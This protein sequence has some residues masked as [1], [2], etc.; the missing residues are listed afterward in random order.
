[1]LDYSLCNLPPYKHQQVGI[2]KIFNEI[3][4][5]LFDEMGAGKT[6]QVIAAAQFLY[7]AGIINRVIV[8]APAAVRSVWYHPEYG[9]IKK[10]SFKGLKK[11]VHSFHAKTD[12]WGDTQEPFLHWM[13]T[14]YEFVRSRSRLDELLP[15]CTSK[16]LLVLDES[17]AIKNYK[18]EQTKA[19]FEIRAKCGR[20]VILNG[21]PIS[22]NPGDLYTQSRIMHFDILGCKTW[23]NYRARYGVLGGFMNRQIIEWRNLEDIQK[24]LAPHVLRRLKIDC[25][26]LPPKL[27]PVTIAVPLTPATWEVYRN[28]RDEMVSWLSDGTVSTASQAIVKAMRL[29]QI[30]SGFLGGM[31]Q[32]S[33]DMDDEEHEG[34]G[35]PIPPKFLSAEKTGAF[36][37]WYKDQLELDPN[38][39]VLIWCRFRA[40]VEGVA[41]QFKLLFPKTQIGLIWG[42][43]KPAERDAAK[44]LLDPRSMPE[45]PVAVIGTPATGSMGLTMTGT[46]VVVYLSNDFSLKTR[47]QSEDRVHRPGQTQPVSYFDYVATGPKGQK[48]IDH[49][50][51]KALR[52]KEDIANWTTSA[53]VNA[54]LEE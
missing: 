15:F 18:A 3:Y 33:F 5:G 27:E 32:I 23:F 36:M 30:T 22:N 26:D 47:L 24:R 41:E 14:N 21:T 40:Q 4:V 42:G 37:L 50:I 51:L 49:Q 6:F 20:I 13:V 11:L 38:F 46:S 12:A 7:M 29:A 48:T 9:E 31:E 34:I 54:L 2:E 1:M 19:C 28:M 43:Q 45:G 16:T 53:W 8:I 52:T 44:Q 17:S 35:K 39:K 25:L 10:H